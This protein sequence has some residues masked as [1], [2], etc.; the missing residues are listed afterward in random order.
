MLWEDQKTDIIE[1]DFDDTTLSK[2]IHLQVD[3]PACNA[4]SHFQQAAL[5]NFVVQL[6]ALDQNSRNLLQTLRVLANL[7]ADSSLPARAQSAPTPTGPHSGIP[8]AC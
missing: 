1:D 7:E 2:E 6:Q 8:S 3:K 5:M 4:L